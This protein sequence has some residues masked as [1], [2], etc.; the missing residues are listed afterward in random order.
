MAQ[1]LPLLDCR[2]PLT[3]SCAKASKLP[4]KSRGANIKPTVA[5]L[6]SLAYENGLLPTALDQLVSLLVTPSHLD[7]ASLN[8]IAR[9][10][11]PVARVSRD[12]VVRIIGALGHGTLKPSLTIQV[13]LL[14]WLIM[15]H[16]VLETPVVLAQAYGVLFNLLDT[17]AIRPNVCHLLALITR[18]KHVKPF[19]IQAL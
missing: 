10:L 7:Q 9:N 18:R 3:Y 2:R 19:R 4:A 1:T 11:Y 17:A 16:H 8:A 13:A 14:K 5:S 15:I 12:V 6:A